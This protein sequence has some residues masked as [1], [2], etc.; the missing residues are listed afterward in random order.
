MAIIGE[1][2]YNPTY[3]VNIIVISGEDTPTIAL[4]IHK[5]IVLIGDNPL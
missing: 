3:F 5:I 2:P 4:I 1:G